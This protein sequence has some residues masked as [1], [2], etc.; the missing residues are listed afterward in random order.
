MNKEEI[1]A[2]SRQENKDQDIY[3]MEVLK[4]G[5]NAGAVTAVILATVFFIIQIAVGKG[6]N[7]GL[8]A[9]VFS[10]LGTGF[11]VKAVKLKR[12]H[13]IAVAVA[14]IIITLVLSAAHIYSLITASTIL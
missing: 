6:I 13:E 5:G 9:I 11:V 3:E 2:K 12:K 4:L 8:H 10:V 7:Y 14:Y 1:L